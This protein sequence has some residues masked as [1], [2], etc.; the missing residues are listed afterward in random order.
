MSHLG[1]TLLVEAVLLALALVLAW[2]RPPAALR[3]AD[4]LDAALGWVVSKPWLAI[5]LPGALLIAL[6]LA[7]L[8]L[9]PF[10]EIIGRDESSLVLGAETLLQGRLAM[11]PHPLAPFFESVYVNQSPAYQSMYF[12]GR[13]IDLAIGQALFGDVRFG[14]LLVIAIAMSLLTWALRPWMSAKWA[15]AGA[16]LMMA[17]FGLFGS[18]ATRPN[19]TGLVTLGAVLL[20]GAYGRLRHRINWLA[21][22]A[23]A[24]GLATLAISR[25]LEGLFVSAPLVLSL[26]WRWRAAFAL[27][28]WG[29]IVTFALPMIV[30]VGLAGW[31]LVANNV[32]GTGSPTEAPYAKNRTEYATT[33]VLFFSPRP[34]PSRPVPDHLRA[35]YIEEGKRY[36]EMQTLPGVIE[37]F[38][39]KILY[40]GQYFVG[41]LFL[42][43]L[44]GGRC[45]VPERAGCDR[46][47]CHVLRLLP[48]GAVHLALLCPATV[49]HLCV[50]HYQRVAAAPCLGWRATRLCT[51]ADTGFDVGPACPH[52]HAGVGRYRQLRGMSPA[53]LPY[54]AGEQTA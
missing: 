52:R 3:L 40:I 26:V 32:A 45:L 35:F 50:V 4:R 11:P 20:V 10:G 7:L 24:V 34:T 6:R 5:L 23:L 41:L 36:E 39:V 28:S 46:S 16:I 19:G 15:L 33:P 9:Y 21:S 30:L 47:H 8:P 38:A 12:P 54:D 42:G 48:A 17:H 53:S 13:F 44:P 37:Q 31:L 49:W 2:Q 51:R 43:P 27:R 14:M 22:I 1:P 25:P 29:T 18:L